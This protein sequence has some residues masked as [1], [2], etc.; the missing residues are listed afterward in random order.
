[1]FTYPVCTICIM[2]EMLPAHNTHVLHAIT[3]KDTT[4]TGMIVTILI[5]ITTNV[6]FT[7][8]YLAV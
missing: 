3:N 6:I 4:L 2:R 5:T 8:G 7:S 1:M